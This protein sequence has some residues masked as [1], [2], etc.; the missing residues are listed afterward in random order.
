[1]V[2]EGGE[3]RGDG[4]GDV[5]RVVLPGKHADVV[6]EKRVDVGG[7][8]GDQRAEDQEEHQRKE[9]AVLRHRVQSAFAAENQLA[10]LD[11]RVEEGL[12]R[13]RGRE[14]YVLRHD[15]VLDLESDDSGEQIGNSGH[16]KEA[17][18]GND[19]SPVVVHFLSLR[20]ML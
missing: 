7:R 14:R 17:F 1:M 6:R 10:A 16:E 13:E 19:R 20:D 5:Q 3:Q 9:R 12:R 11:D 18:V 8:G 15:A 2:E 4:G